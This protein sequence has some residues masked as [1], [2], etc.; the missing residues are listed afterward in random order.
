M[1]ER[2]N[3]KG[4]CNLQ[5]QASPGLR[6]DQTSI[7]PFRRSSPHSTGIKLNLAKPEQREN[8]ALEGEPH[9]Q[10]RAGDRNHKSHDGL[11]EL[12]YYG[13]LQGKMGGEDRKGCNNPVGPKD[14][15]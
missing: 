7:K 8:Q 11:E 3:G 15:A 5:L 1:D 13:Q 2:A 9:P 6:E 14:T 4:H 10:E 12:W